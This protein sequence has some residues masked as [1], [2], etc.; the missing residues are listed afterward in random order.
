MNISKLS[1]FQLSFLYES[2]HGLYSD[3]RFSDGK[4]DDECAALFTVLKK[5]IKSRG[6]DNIIELMESVDNWLD[7]DNNM[8]EWH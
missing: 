5:E 6:F 8:W 3:G 1:N 7:E 2:M 4:L